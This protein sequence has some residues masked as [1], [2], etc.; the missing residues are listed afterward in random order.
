[1]VVS[2]WIGFQLV[3]LLATL[4]HAHFGDGVDMV[5]DK[6]CQQLCVSDN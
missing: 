6:L 3:F 1:M 2:G 4:G 5:M